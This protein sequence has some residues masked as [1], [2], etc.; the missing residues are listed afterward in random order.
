MQV[1]TVGECD[2]ISPR[3][4]RKLKTISFVGDI[5]GPKSVS[6]LQKMAFPMKVKIG[7]DSPTHKETIDVSCTSPIRHPSRHTTKKRFLPGYTLHE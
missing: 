7:V 4:P 2:S 6:Q 5:F 3:Y 1:Q